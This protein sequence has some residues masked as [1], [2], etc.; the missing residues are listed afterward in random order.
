MYLLSA[1]LFV[2]WLVALC[3][4]LDDLVPA[5]LELCDRLLQLCSTVELLG[6][7]TVLQGLFSL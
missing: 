2:G 1:D 5:V 6:R 7:D 3:D 4:F